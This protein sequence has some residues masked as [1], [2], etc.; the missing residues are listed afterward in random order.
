MTNSRVSDFELKMKMS[1]IGV[2]Y[3]QPQ[4]VVYAQEGR[5]ENPFFRK[6]L[7]VNKEEVLNQVELDVSLYRNKARSSYESIPVTVTNIPQ[8]A[9]AESPVVSRPRA[10]ISVYDAKVG[11]SIAN[12]SSPSVNNSLRYSR[13]P[14]MTHR[15]SS[16]AMEVVQEDKVEEIEKD[17]P[18]SLFFNGKKFYLNSC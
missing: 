12:E 18:V 13:T 11:D 3:K 10:S 14:D 6:N 4:K 2:P 7:L 15:P 5:L 8:S 9:Y 17:Q 1:N 16:R